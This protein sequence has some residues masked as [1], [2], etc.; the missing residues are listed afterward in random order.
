MAKYLITLVVRNDTLLIRGAPLAKAALAKELESEFPKAPAPTV[1]DMATGRGAF[2]AK[3][4]EASFAQLE[5]LV[6][7]VLVGHEVL[8]ESV[9]NAQHFKFAHIEIESKP[10]Q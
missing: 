5:A 3:A 8:V 4:H 7:R 10:Q 1:A 6:R 2:G 9:G